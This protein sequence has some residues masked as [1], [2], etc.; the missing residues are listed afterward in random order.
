MLSLF[1]FGP[2]SDPEASTC[3]QTYRKIVALGSKRVSHS[4]PDAARSSRHYCG[5]CHLFQLI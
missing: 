4:A 3:C 5:R 2:R 1:R